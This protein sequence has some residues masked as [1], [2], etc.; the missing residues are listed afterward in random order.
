MRIWECPFVLYN[1][2]FLSNFQNRWNEKD[3]NVSGITEKLKLLALWE[4]CI[5][6]CLIELF[7]AKQSVIH[8]S[9]MLAI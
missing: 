2:A 3:Y 6:D 9:M 7:K 4:C 1:V 8:I 5:T